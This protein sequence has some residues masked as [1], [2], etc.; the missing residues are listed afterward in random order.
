MRTPKQHLRGAVV[1]AT[2]QGSDDLASRVRIPLYAGRMRPYKPRSSRVSVGVAR[3]RTSLLKA[4]SANHKICSAVTGNGD[5]RLITEKLLLRLQ[6]NKT[7]CFLK[8]VKIM[9]N[10]LA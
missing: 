7:F 10:C 5:S 8:N 9:I 6:T 4:M 3:K 2:V 1:R